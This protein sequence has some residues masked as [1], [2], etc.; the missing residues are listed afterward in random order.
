MEAGVDVGLGGGHF[1]LGE[2][3]GQLGKSVSAEPLWCHG[4]LERGSEPEEGVV[5]SLGSQKTQSKSYRQQ[6]GCWGTNRSFQGKQ[7]NNLSENVHSLINECHDPHAGSSVRSGVMERGSNVGWGKWDLPSCKDA[8]E[9]GTLRLLWWEV[10]YSC[11]RVAS[12]LTHV[13]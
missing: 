8:H 13:F 10:E 9:K 11:S 2:P 1:W 7:G 4:F 12:T 3:R 5:G 6:P